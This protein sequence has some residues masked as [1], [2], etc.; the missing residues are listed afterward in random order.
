VF[1]GGSNAV[2]IRLGSEELGPFWAATLRFGLSSI[3]LLALS[4]LLRL[5]LPRGRARIGI[6]LYGLTAFAGA[7]AALYQGLEGAPAGTVQV[8][9]ATAPLVTMLMAVVLGQERFTIR[10]IAGAVVALAGISVIVGDQL[11]VAV[12]LPSLVAVIIGVC[13]IALSNV[14]VKQI[15]PGHPVTAN[16]FGMAIGT[17]VLL[18]LAIFVDEPRALPEA[19]T[20]WASLVYLVLIGSIGLFMLTLYVLARW[21]ASAT[22]YATLAMPLVTIVVA[23]VVLGESVGPPFIVG[24]GLVVAGVHVGIS[25]SRSKATRSSRP[26]APTTPGSPPH[27]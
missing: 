14:A 20:S 25:A 10:G 7:Y 24:A 19:A 22:A 21:S 9:I 1:C 27:G 11:A 13:F 15:P 3:V 2:A 6:L 8:I 26:G 5:P 18:A 17:A 12:P 4:I 16:A 23:A